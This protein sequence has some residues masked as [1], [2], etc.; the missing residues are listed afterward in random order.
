M[1]G[2]VK[3][4][5]RSVV[6]GYAAQQRAA[7]SQDRLPSNGLLVLFL[8]TLVVSIVI[9]LVLN[10]LVSKKLSGVDQFLLG[11]SIYV[12]LTLTTQAYHLRRLDANATKE[13]ALW[14][15]DHEFDR[16]LANIRQSFSDISRNRRTDP[17]FFTL[18]FQRS[19][20]LFESTINEAASNCELLVDEN[21][22]STTDMLLA[23]FG[24]RDADIARFVHYFED[25]DWMFDTWAKNYCVRLWQLVDS[26]TLREVKRLFIFKSEG[27]QEL[28]P[29]KKLMEF[30]GANKGY[31]YRV[32]SEATYKQI[33]RDYHMREQFKDFGI[34]GD[35]YVYRTLS[36][37]PERIEGVFSSS[38]RKVR[39]YKEV[40]RK[41]WEHAP[42]PAPPAGS[43]MTPS[44][45]FGE[46]ITPVSIGP[47]P[48]ASVGPRPPVPP[49]VADG[50]ARE[51]AAVTDEAA[52]NSG[53][54]SS[55]G[56]QQTEHPTAGAT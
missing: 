5:A 26:G 45:L 36:A 23:S 29:S 28:E 44:E 6:D 40:F 54:P 3:R 24:G 16:R 30:H 22:L 12:A 10:T 51:A 9:P 34:Y 56:V 8:V 13:R 19:L 42:D 31:D 11:V 7:N 2:K 39:E 41:C 47:M 1:S 53:Q 32:L 20:E 4:F 37:V 55:D 35:W 50:A 33:V 48:P 18:Y 38:E 21:H 52:S 27:E 46:A 43:K 25:N 15:I 17:E 49:A 14:R